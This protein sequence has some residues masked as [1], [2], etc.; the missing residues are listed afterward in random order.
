VH[1]NGD[2]GHGGAVDPVEF[3]ASVGAPRGIPSD[4]ETKQQ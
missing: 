1:E 2:A 3:M 4:P